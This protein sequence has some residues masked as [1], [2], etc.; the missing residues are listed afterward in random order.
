[1]GTTSYV[2]GDKIEHRYRYLCRWYRSRGYL[3]WAGLGRHSSHQAGKACLLLSLGF[4]TKS[5]AMTK[6]RFLF[7]LSS[8]LRAEPQLA[9]SVGLEQ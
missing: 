2:D 7:S 8:F 9:T 5:Q 1:M 3:L 6:T 4:P